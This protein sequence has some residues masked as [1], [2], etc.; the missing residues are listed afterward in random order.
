MSDETC[1]F[2]AKAVDSGDHTGG[3]DL[4][5]VVECEHALKGGFS[6]VW[7][8]ALQEKRDADPGWGVDDVVSA[9]RGRGYDCTF[10]YPEFYV[11]Y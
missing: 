6:L 7:A 8:T 1:R 11:S 5:M 3:N 10:V 4:L 9:V 2:Y